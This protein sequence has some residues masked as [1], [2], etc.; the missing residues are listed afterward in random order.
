MR[1]SSKKKG[2][3]LQEI[4]SLKNTQPLHIMRS[5]P[6][7]A[8]ESE[9]QLDDDERRIIRSSTMFGNLNKK[10]VTVVRKPEKHELRKRSTDIENYIEFEQ[11][12]ASEIL[13]TAILNSES[14]DCRKLWSMIKAFKQHGESHKQ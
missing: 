2:R 8:C 9:E 7:A 10:N 14:E 4:I 6:G 11:R 12:P 13:T 5:R 3:H 1:K